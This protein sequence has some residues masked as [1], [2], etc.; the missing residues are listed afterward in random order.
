MQTIVISSPTPV[1]NEFRIIENLFK[2]GL[3]YFHLRKPEFNFSEYENYIL[4]IPEKY[5]NR[6]IIHSYFELLE[7]YNLKGFHFNKKTI[8]LYERNQ[9]I[10][11]SYSAHTLTELKINSDKFDYVFISPIFD[12]ISK[13]G[14]KSNFTLS[15]I[16]SFFIEN[17]ITNAV[18]LGGINFLNINKIKDINFFGAA[19][20]GAIWNK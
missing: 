19:M 9:N 10:H 12:S 16:Q 7:K 3:K 4:K 8:H 1:K 11:T 14:Y 17:N 6:I 18:A 15:E 2:D 13:P 5:R 20:L